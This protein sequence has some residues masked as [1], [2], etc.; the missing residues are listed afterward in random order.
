MTTSEHKRK[1]ERFSPGQDVRWTFPQE[2]KIGGHVITKAGAPRA[3]VVMHKAEYPGWWGI[4]GWI[5]IVAGEP[6]P[7][8]ASD[9]EITEVKSA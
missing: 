9:E 3:A 5:L 7:V 6:Y 4:H 2:T 8:L 1:A